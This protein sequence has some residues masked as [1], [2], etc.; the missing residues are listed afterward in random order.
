MSTK[1]SLEQIERR[2]EIIETI[3]LLR[4]PGG[5]RSA[6]VFE[7]LRSR[8]EAVAGERRRHLLDLVEL[9]REVSRKAERSPDGEAA[10][11]LG[12]IDQ[13]LSREGVK[14]HGREGDKYVPQ[15]FEV[16][17]DKPSGDGVVTRV[18]TAAYV[19]TQTGEVISQGRVEVSGAP[20]GSLEGRAE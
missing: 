18:H 20:S 10:A 1:Q 5:A 13:A 17:G 8:V 4:D 16:M 11:F 7:G 19:D 14:S 9:H 2:L 12:T 15:L 6:E 3:L